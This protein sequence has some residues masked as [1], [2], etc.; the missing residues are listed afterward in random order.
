[1]F[2]KWVLKSE[3]QDSAHTLTKILVVSASC[4]LMPFRP[5]WIESDDLSYSSKQAESDAHSG[6]GWLEARPEAADVSSGQVLHNNLWLVFSQKT[7]GFILMNKITYVHL[8]GAPGIKQDR[9][10]LADLSD[11]SVKGRAAETHEHSQGVGCPLRIC[12][13]SVNTF[14]CTEKTLGAQ[15]N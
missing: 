1:M 7:Q 15:N 2:L 14:R 5:H 9:L 11:V 4:W 12:S 8:G 10:H 6:G 13:E 3:S